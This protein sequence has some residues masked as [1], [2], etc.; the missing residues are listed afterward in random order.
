MIA[1]E[2][3]GSFGSKLNVYAEEGLLGY[4]ALKLNRPVK[5]TKSAAKI[6]KRPFMAG[7]GG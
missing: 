4:L 3:G 7:A 5:W 2:V 1:P 6:F